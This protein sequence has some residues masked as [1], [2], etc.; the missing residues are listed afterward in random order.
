MQIVLKDK[1][2]IT[3]PGKPCITCINKDKANHCKNYSLHKASLI[4]KKFLWLLKRNKNA[5][6]SF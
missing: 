5:Q 2:K 4:C 6:E 3:H 1:R